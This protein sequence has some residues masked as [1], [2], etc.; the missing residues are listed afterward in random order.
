LFLARPG[1]YF[2]LNPTKKEIKKVRAR[3]IGRASVYD[4][5][6]KIVQAF[7]AGAEHVKVTDLSRFIGAKSG[8]TRAG[9]EPDY[10]YK[11]SRDYGRWVMKP[12]K[13]GFSPF[14]K[15]SA[16]KSNGQLALRRV[17]GESAPYQKGVVSEES[18]ML[19]RLAIELEEQPQGPD[20][21]E[22]YECQ[23]DE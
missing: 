16:V 18:E 3:G 23:N 7:E 19:Q 8:I 2:P 4:H 9:S 17:E 14:P 15:R 20:Y 13:L 11:R 12:V 22:W 1:I 10:R 21:G 6:D 5:W